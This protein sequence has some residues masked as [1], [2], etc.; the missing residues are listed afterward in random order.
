[1]EPAKT[2]TACF[3]IAD[4]SGYTG[5]LAG[6]EL[7]HAQDII[8]DILDNIVRGLRPPFRLAKFEGDAL[9]AL[10]FRQYRGHSRLAVIRLSD[11]DG[12]TWRVRSAGA[13]DQLSFHR[14][15]DGGT[16]VEFCFAMP[17][18]KERKYSR[19]ARRGLREFYTW[20]MTNLNTVLTGET[21]TAA[22]IEEPE[23]L[24]MQERF[25]TQPVRR[26]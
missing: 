20:A 25:L 24:P 26:V 6:V 14:K 22:V 17:K 15:P 19:S 9:L 16:R 4:L 3:L 10:R 11:S 21:A 8:A 23:L 5:Y 18:P 7:D 13:A 12:G 2:E 1:M